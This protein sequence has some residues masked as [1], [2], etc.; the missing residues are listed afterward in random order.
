MKEG[1][2]NVR[3]FERYMYGSST[4]EMI[5]ERDILEDRE[6]K[7]LKKIQRNL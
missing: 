7:E 2:A 3:D 1:T 5:D 6:R 4:K